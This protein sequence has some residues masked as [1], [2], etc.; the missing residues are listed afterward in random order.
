MKTKIFYLSMLLAVM[1]GGV[2]DAW[3]VNYPHKWDFTMIINGKIL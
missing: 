1:V 3:G 2:S